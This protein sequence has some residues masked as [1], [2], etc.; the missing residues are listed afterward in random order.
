MSWPPRAS[1]GTTANCFTS[2]P[3]LLSRELNSEGGRWT[4]GP[5]T[6]RQTESIFRRGLEPPT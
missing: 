5:A 4:L 6:R 3:Q 1:G 2:F